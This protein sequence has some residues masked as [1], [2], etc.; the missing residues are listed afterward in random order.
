[1]SM[2]N[3]RSGATGARFAIAA[4]II[5][6]FA[7]T[8]HAQTWPVAGNRTVTSSF[9][10][11]ENNSIHGGLDIPAAAATA[12]RAVRGFTIT[13]VWYRDAMGV[14]RMSSV[15]GFGNGRDVFQVIGTDANGKTHLYAHLQNPAMGNITVGQAIVEGANFARVRGVGDTFGGSFDHIHYNFSN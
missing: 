10:D 2:I 7:G 8:A 14:G 12:V 1:M 11:D 3:I 9:G 5:A 15:N 13:S 6:A 4:G